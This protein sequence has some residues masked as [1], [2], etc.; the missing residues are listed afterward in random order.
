MLLDSMSP[1][2]NCCDNGFIE[3]VDGR[4]SRGHAKCI[5]DLVWML[6]VTVFQCHLGFRKGLFMARINRREVL[7]EGEIQ[8]VL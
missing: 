5:D 6:Q 2:D 8:A 3:S 7:S 4:E 1:A